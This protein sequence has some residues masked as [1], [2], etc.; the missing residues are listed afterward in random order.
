MRH[1]QG[2]QIDWFSQSL[3]DIDFSVN[4]DSEGKAFQFFRGQ[5]HLAVGQNNFLETNKIFICVF[6]KG[7]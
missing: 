3:S 7:L 5:G 1:I 2:E 6:E 4:I